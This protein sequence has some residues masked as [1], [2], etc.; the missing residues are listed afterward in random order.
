[1][2]VNRGYTNMNTANISAT[3]TMYRVIGVTG[4]L[5][6]IQV[7]PRSTSLKKKALSHDG[8]KYYC[9]DVGS[10]KRWHYEFVR[11]FSMV[12]E[13]ERGRKK[14]NLFPLLSMIIQRVEPCERS[15]NVFLPYD[16][17][18]GHK[19]DQNAARLYSVAVPIVTRVAG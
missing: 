10:F 9:H 12:T 15:S 1:M 2:I 7:L 13:W 6:R 19:S 8:R 17:F 4:Y 16:L 11:R 18:E 14:K 3:G 5:N